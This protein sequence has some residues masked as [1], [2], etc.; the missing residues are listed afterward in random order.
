MKSPVVVHVQGLKVLD[1]DGVTLRL[2]YECPE[3]NVQVVLLD[4]TV[5]QVQSAKVFGALVDALV[6]LSWNI[7]A[8]K[9]IATTC[10]GGIVCDPPSLPHGPVA[11][12]ERE[13]GG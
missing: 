3:G 5:V 7:R 2:D 8:A 12:D 4:G 11:I 1:I 9:R 10:T 13:K 6:D